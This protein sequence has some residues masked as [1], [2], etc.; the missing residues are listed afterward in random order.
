MKRRTFLAK[1]AMAVAGSTLVGSAWAKG[2]AKPIGLQLYTLRQV[3]NKDVKG[4]LKQLADWGYKKFETY[5]YKD[6]M[7]FGMT[8]KEFNTYVK[9]LGVEVTSG[10]Y[11]LDIL[12]SDGWEKAVLDA[13]EAGQKYIT[14]PYINAPERTMDGFKKVCADINKAA[15]VAK[16]YGVKMAYHNHDF[17]FKEVDGVIPFDMMMSE[18]D[19]KLVSMEMDIYWVVRAG[20]DPVEYFK[21]YPGRFEQWHVKDMDKANPANNADVGTGSIDYKA[22]FVHAKKSGMKH[23]YIEQET[24]P[25]DPMTSTKNSIDFLKTIV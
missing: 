23:Y 3:I 14:V 5:G 4:T 6:G 11:G 21:K 20:H 16:N 15:V 19:S 7:L 1:S 24:Y 17:E 18:L 10:H 8:S 12:R 22:L 2:K 25:V 13:K 9:G